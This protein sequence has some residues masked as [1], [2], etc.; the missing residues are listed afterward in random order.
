MGERSK[1]KEVI[2]DEFS[3][4]EEAAIFWD[5]YDFADYWDETSEVEVDIQAPRRQWGALSPIGAGGPS[6][7]ND[8][9]TLPATR[10]S[11]C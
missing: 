8:A 6:A 1:S 5:S 2:P 7:T 9:K 10:H 11:K 4:I 3:T